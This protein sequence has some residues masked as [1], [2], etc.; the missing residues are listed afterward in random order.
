MASS[1]ALPARFVAL[2]IRANT[3]MIGA[4]DA[5]QHV[6]L[7]PRQVAR[8]ALESWARLHLRPADA[9]VI[10]A[11]GCV[12][13]LHDLLAPLV[14]SITIAH[15]QLARLMPALHTGA[16]AREA[17][18][19]AQLHAAGLVPALWAP[20]PEV[21]D[22]RA[23]IAQRRRLLKQRSAAR[24]ALHELLRRY[25][26][27]PPGADRLAAD[28]PDWWETRSLAPEDHL[29]ARTS[30]ADLSRA[31][32]LLAEAE[33]DLERRAAELPWHTAVATLLSHIPGMRPLD[34]IILLAEIGAIARFPSAGQLAAYA[35]LIG[36]ST[37]SMQES[38]REI[39]S[40]MLEIARAAVRAD[41][42]W[43]DTFA[44]LEQRTGSDRASVAIARKLLLEVWETLTAY[45][46]VEKQQARQAAA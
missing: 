8:G 22:L 21:R 1:P 46:A 7:T 30:L 41:D 37:H 12:W 16:G 9:L 25:R 42:I 24:C 6:A 20:P 36:N 32:T 35:G 38:R 44:A 31:A 5:H 18:A 3:V 27:T 14:A 17:I 15:P 34:A 33:A 29:R 26:L 13:D 28:R 2:D 45:V 10:A 23:Q 39:R 40:T 19:L 11:P 43:R 4:V